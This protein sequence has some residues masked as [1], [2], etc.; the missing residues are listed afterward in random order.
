[1]VIIPAM[2]AA[3]TDWLA[4]QDALVPCTT[5]CVYDRP[6]L[7]WSE[8]ALRWPTATGIASDLRRLLTGGG[9]APP[10]VIAGHSLGGVI[11]R[12][13]T[14]MYSDEVA[15]MVL[16]DSTHPGQVGRLQ[17]AWL[18]DYRGGKLAE[19]ALDYARPLGLRRAWSSLRSQAPASAEQVMALSSRAR[20]AQAKELLAFES[21]CRQAGLILGD[22]GDLPLTVIT[23]SE[24]A[25]A[26]PEDSR[27]QRVRSRFYPGWAQLQDELATLSADSAHI[28]APCA[29]HHI[30]FDDP[31]LV[32]SSI[33]DLVER[34]RQKADAIGGD[35]VSN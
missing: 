23:S 27:A 1:M 9:I 34:V 11:A 10:F 8:P 3:A 30:Q 24:R 13:F 12:V 6:G 14:H 2:G 5:V 19:V 17:K 15:G 22:L 16:I 31:E 29:G 35:V 25:P 26:V 33:T 32:T 28:M 20:R 4:V 18:Q 21:I 7:G